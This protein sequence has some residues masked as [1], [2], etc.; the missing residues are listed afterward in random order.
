MEWAK[1]RKATGENLKHNFKKR[2][3]IHPELK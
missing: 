2:D 1:I 3:E